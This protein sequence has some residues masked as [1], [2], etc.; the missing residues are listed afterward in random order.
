M[1]AIEYRT[2]TGYRKR[3][4]LSDFHRDGSGGHLTRCRACRSVTRKAW[5]DSYSEKQSAYRR[6]S[7]LSRYGLTEDEYE[8]ML[9]AQQGG[10]AM[11]GQQCQTERRLAVDHDH[12][13][14]RVRGLLCLTCNRGLGAY[15]ALQAAAGRYLAEYGAG[16]L[17]ISHGVALAKQH[18]TPRDGASVG[19][20]RCR[21][22]RPPPCWGGRSRAWGVRA[23]RL[24]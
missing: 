17:H 8:A 2:C 16:N 13:S 9:A 12:V 19:T 7:K 21:R 3:K 5:R 23:C 6:R 10:C 1:D 24:P 15:E 20:A 4:P 14:G 18:G 11:C 22:D